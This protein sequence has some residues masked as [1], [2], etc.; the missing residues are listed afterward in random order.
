M[1]HKWWRYTYYYIIHGKVYLCNVK[2]VINNISILYKISFIDVKKDKAYQ[3]DS[4]AANIWPNVRMIFATIDLYYFIEWILENKIIKQI[5]L[6]CDG[7]QRKRSN[8]S[9]LYDE[10]LIAS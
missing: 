9:Q 6:D 3:V 4:I 5:T 7:L 2:Y 10:H 1:L 8:V